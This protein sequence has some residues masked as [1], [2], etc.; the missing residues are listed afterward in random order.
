MTCLSYNF[1]LPCELIIS[2]ENQRNKIFF[3]LFDDSDATGS[4]LLVERIIPVILGTLGGQLKGQTIIRQ[5]VQ[6]DS[7][8]DGHS[9]GQGGALAACLCCRS[10]LAA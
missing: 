2:F 5:L 6:P 1:I 8:F 9:P 7:G 10:T 4:N 3:K